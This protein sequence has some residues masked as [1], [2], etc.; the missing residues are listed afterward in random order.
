MAVLIF[1]SILEFFV[2]EEDKAS[3]LNWLIP[4][5]LVFQLL[6][7]I[8]QTL[9]QNRHNKIMKMGI[10]PSI[11]VYVEKTNRLNSRGRKVGENWCINIH[12]S[13]TDAHNVRYAVKE[14]DRYIKNDVPFF[15]LRK[16]QPET[17]YIYNNED[18]FIDNQ[19]EIKISFED[20]IRSPRYY[21]YFKKD[22]KE[23]EFRTIS[24]GIR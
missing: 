19:I 10:V 14:N 6:I 22:A 7:I 2:K 8:I 11:N 3:A 15:L 4:L 1:V 24:T 9:N 20:M 17:V 23:K 16:S 12:N 18:T 13:G 5:I 21:A